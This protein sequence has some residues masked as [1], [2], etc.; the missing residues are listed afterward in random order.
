[1]G[2]GIALAG[3]AL[4]L[5]YALAGLMVFVIARCLGELALNVDPSQIF[6]SHTARYLGR[7]VAFV[8]GWSYWACAIIVSMA[9]LTGGAALVHA[10]LPA[11]PTWLVAL[12]ELA[13]LLAINRLGVRAF[14]ETEFWMAFLKI[15]TIAGFLLIGAAVLLGV[16][17]VE[18]ASVS[19]LWS[20]GG[21]FPHGAAGFFA[22]LS[23]AL[24]AFGGTELIGV[25]S[26]EA[27]DPRRNIPRATNGLLA[28]VVLFY[29]GSTFVVLAL[30]PWKSLSPDGS[31]MVS[32]LS[33]VGIPAASAF[34][35]VVL[36][37]AALSSCNSLLYASSRIARALSEM[38]AAPAAL[39]HVSGRGVPDRALLL[40]GALTS[41]AI[42]LNFLLPATLFQLLLGAGALTIVTNWCI[43]LVVHLRYGACEAAPRRRSSPRRGPPGA[44][45]RSCCWPP[46]SSSSRRNRAGCG[47]P[48]ACSWSSGRPGPGIV[49]PS[50]GASRADAGQ[51][52]ECKRS[53]TMN[54]P[55]NL[56]VAAPRLPGRDADPRTSLLQRRPHP[57]FRR[58]DGRPAGQAPRPAS[59]GHAPDPSTPAQ[60]PAFGRAVAGPG[61]PRIVVADGDPAMRT[62]LAEFLDGSGM[63]VATASDGRELEEQVA[64][65]PS[66]IVLDRQLGP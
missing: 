17:H 64:A 35:N 38:R 31:P 6:L 60:P 54:A 5:A 42:L 11:I 2:Q 53:L 1:M 62:R 9:E 59:R 56:R 37:S 27:E 50:A 29:L 45:M 23:I 58:P 28:R 55:S 49:L 3:P 15:A 44:T 51:S 21:F 7:R 36:I 24:F 18:G 34:L 8:Q 47:S 65:Q 63:R 25:A 46:P 57:P 33:G 66:L 14:G 12:V 16:P 4:L 19:N 61:S 20:D 43:I 39:G 52:P 22:A 13:I 26:A 40:A 10:W 32:V 30:V 48:S 41:S